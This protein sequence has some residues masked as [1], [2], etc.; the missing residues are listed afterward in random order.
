M[1]VKK[2][3]YAIYNKIDFGPS[4]GAYDLG[5][6]EKCNQNTNSQAYQLG[7]DYNVPP[8]YARYDENTKKLLTGHSGGFKCTE[9]E[10]YYL[11]P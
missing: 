9:Y 10:V 1:T 11:G 3:L 5:I 6:R 4:F 2:P 8:G 7:D